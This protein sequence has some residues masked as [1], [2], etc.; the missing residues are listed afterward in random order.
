MR[1]LSLDIEN[2]RSYSSAR[3]AFP[4]G[5]TLFE[6]DIG[7][8][9]SSLLYAIEFALFGLGDLKAE[10]VLRHGAR[11]GFVALEA[12]INGRQYVFRRTLE[13]KKTVQQGEACIIED[14][15]SRSYAPSEM[16]PAVLK[17]LGFNEPPSPKSTSEIYRYAVFT[18]QEEM[19]LVLSL[20]DDERL[21]TIR[22]ALRVEEYKTAQDNAKTLLQ[23]V[24]RSEDRLEGALE[25]AESLD[26]EKAEIEAKITSW[27]NETKK[28]G[29]AAK[30]ASDAFVVADNAFSAISKERE[31]LLVL[32]NEA[33]SLERAIEEKK[34]AAK[35]CADDAVRVER[36]IAEKK[37]RAQAKPPSKK[38]ADL[39]AEAD[40]LR[41]ELMEAS[42]G[43]SALEMKARESDKLAKAGK[44]PTC[45][46][47]TGGDF[48]K[49]AEHALKEAAAKREVAAHLEA[50][51]KT[52]RA[53]L[54]AAVAAE[55]EYRR[56]QEI[57]KEI[58][59]K[60]AFLAQLRERASKA[61]TELP[62]LEQ[63]LKDAH[64]SMKGADAVFAD[65]AALETARK[66]A[67]AC[68]MDAERLLAGA[69]ASLESLVER[70]SSLAEKIAGK[71]AERKMLA[72]VVAVRSWLEEY[73]AP[74]LA[75][76]EAHV[77]ASYN[78]DF[79]ALFAKWF[80][81]LVEEGELDV[82]VDES[83]TPQVVQ[84]GFEQD[85]SALSGGE[86]T[87]VALAY[88]LALNALVRRECAS[89]KTNLLILDEPTDGFS[90]EQI[91]RM[92][93]V[94]DELKSEQVILVS[95]ER[96][97]EAFSDKIFRITKKA[98]ESVVE[99]A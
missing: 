36:E 53:E 70:L 81:L 86:K 15:V 10:H 51:E 65:Y 82:S 54:D 30:C 56:A 72:K 18:P 61:E 92:R 93:D 6:G 46:Q 24:R 9:K 57:A 31:R 79:N 32:K 62:G 47:P 52:L 7:S 95:H 48:A 41:K 35:Q 74:S 88:R 64:A 84:N 75:S 85:V 67:D 63:K 5:V 28:L 55:N 22:K 98:G 45:G 44:C 39:R 27:K 78:A 19:K 1:L 34:K 11:H 21:Q 23:D 58:A 8:G 26:K 13:R 17:I 2:V 37:A 94:F 96:E 60:E 99:A 73:F 97:L 33:Q 87:A 20:K 14:G 83:F 50:K 12:E 66:K 4:P 43:A 16:K 91:Y 71:A 29:D 49:H 42:G 68:R 59:D 76:I 89:L 90:R 69:R 38:S 80:A 25:D 40:A 77:L 3:V